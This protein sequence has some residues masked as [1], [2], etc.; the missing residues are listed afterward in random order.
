MYD[1]KTYEG[2]TLLAD[3]RIERY[4]LAAAS[5]PCYTGKQVAKERAKRMDA[6]RQCAGKAVRAVK[7]KVGVIGIHGPIQ[8]RLTSELM[9]AGGTAADE[10]SLELDI[11]LN[12][13]DV[14]AIVLHVDSP[15]GNSYGIEE[16]SDKIFAGRAR[17]PIY[18]SVDSMACS[19]AYW[20]A[21]AASALWCTPGGDVGSVGVYSVHIDE[22]KAL[23]QAGLS[24]TLITAGEFKAEGFGHVPLTDAARAARQESVDK[25]YAKFI[26]A[27]AR[28]RGVKPSEVKEKF[29]KGRAVDADA[30]LEAKMI[31]K[32]ATFEQMMAQLTGGAGEGSSS[33]A[34]ALEMKRLRHE[35]RMREAAWL[36]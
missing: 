23:E 31:D 10:I 15:G 3:Q 1:L 33:R 36:K 13:A 26:D 35:Q 28:N 9:K 22:G 34:A 16:L 20:L 27:L 24:V 7:G 12:T 6:A 11:L 30:A 2:I 4:I 14:E 21:T 18:A 29:G 25:T 17:K 5:L 8:Q 32:V 19:A